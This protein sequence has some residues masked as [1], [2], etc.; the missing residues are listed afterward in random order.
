VVALVA[1][2]NPELFER[3]SV[4]ADVETEGRLTSGMLVIDRRQIRTALANVDLLTACDVAAV[5]D[6]ILRGMAAA[7]AATD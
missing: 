6:C 4:A 2:T 1:A 5:K 7:A 3:A